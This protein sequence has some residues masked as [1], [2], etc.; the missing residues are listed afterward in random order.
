MST[1][2]VV[3]IEDSVYTKQFILISKIIINIRLV[4]LIAEIKATRNTMTM[5]EIYFKKDLITLE[6]FLKVLLLLY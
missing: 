1:L 2:E 6:I 4:E 5:V 3:L